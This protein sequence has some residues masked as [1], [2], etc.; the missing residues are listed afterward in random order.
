MLMALRNTF[1]GRLR[2]QT[3]RTRSSRLC[4]ALA[5]FYQSDVTWIL[6]PHLLEGRQRGKDR[7]TDPDTVLSLG[8]R[9]NLD[10]HRRRSKGG[11]LLLHTIGY[12]SV[13]CAFGEGGKI[14]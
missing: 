9:D 2:D 1:G 8:R 11:D 10:L 3:R 14:K 4:K 6:T 5:E 13:S 7:T 12:S